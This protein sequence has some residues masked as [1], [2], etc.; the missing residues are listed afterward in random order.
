MKK[1][2]APV[3]DTVRILNQS[4]DKVCYNEGG[5]GISCL[6]RYPHPHQRCKDKVASVFSFPTF[7]FFNS[8]RLCAELII[9]RF[10]KVPLQ[11]SGYYWICKNGTYFYNNESNFC[12]RRWSSCEKIK[13]MNGISYFPYHYIPYLL[14]TYGVCFNIERRSAEK[15]R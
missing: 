6:P 2:S 10:S 4:K 1:L 15:L 14:H 5:A 8:T 12:M 7:H 9:F 3:K 11:L 13:K